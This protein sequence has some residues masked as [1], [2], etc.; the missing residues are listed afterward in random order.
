M[1][2]HR[3]GTSIA[4]K[5]LILLTVAVGLVIAAQAWLNIRSARKS[6]ETEAEQT[7]LNLYG[8]YTN[9]VRALEDSAAA[10][11]TSLAARSDIQDLF[12][13]R[14]RAGLVILLA[15]LF[16]TLA[17]NHDLV[18]LSI[19]GPTGIV[20]ARI[21]RPTQY[22]DNVSYRRAVAVALRTR[23]TVSGIEVGAN[24]L[25]IYSPSPLLYNGESDAAARGNFMG[26][27]EVALDY[28]QSFIEGLKM[29]NGA[30]YRMW[31]AREAVEATPLGPTLEALPAPT[32]LLFYYAG[33]T[34]AAQ[35]VPA[36]VFETVLQSGE[37][38]IEFVSDAGGEYAVLVA[39][40][41]AYGER[42]IGALEII[43]PH[44]DVRTNWQRG[45]IWAALI[46]GG[47]GLLAVGAT[48]FLVDQTG[49]RQ[50]QHLTDVIQRQLEGDRS[51]QAAIK[52]NDEIGRLGHAFNALAR[53]LDETLQG[54]EET[55]GQQTAELRRRS[56]LLEA[57]SEVGRIAAAVSDE[58]ELAAQTTTLVL[59]RF[60][61]YH[62]SI[63]F[64]DSKREWAEYI[65][66]AGAGA[67][68]LDKEKLRLEVGARSMVGWCIEHGQSRI[69]Q[70]AVGDKVRLDH[71]LM[72][73]TRSEAAFPLVARG[74]VIGALDVQSSQAGAFDPDM[75]AALEI[76]ADQ[77]AAALYAS[78]LLE[79]SKE[80]AIAAQR[81]YGEMSRQAWL[82]L[83]HERSEWGYR[84]ADQEVSSVEGG[85][86]P[87]ML[88]AAWTAQMVVEESEEGALLAVPVQVR[89]QVVGV[90]R[91]RKRANETSWSA[92]ERT[93]IENLVT[94]LEQ[95][96]ESGRLFLETQRR[97][98]REQLTRQ[99]TSRMRE[100]LDI[101]TV[102]Q[103][104]AREIRETMAL[105]HVAIRMVAP[106]EAGGPG[107]DDSLESMEAKEKE[108]DDE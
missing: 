92:E 29:H 73:E 32:P 40:I 95:A 50:L 102:L 42:T 75:V 79:E 106:G 76:I 55:V 14:D 99:A 19:E 26:L 16:E 108:T 57:A 74:Q 5:L 90:L 86:R 48:V 52:T 83:L 71:S 1:N 9:Q 31:I 11:S 7:L 4:L 8:D 24:H 30:D 34:T 78:R 23:S 17:A 49:L 96:L 63:F 54:L 47:L 13:A 37:P 44:A 21:H 25:G 107:T 77:V 88:Q 91:F 98:A 103:A 67:A 93:L 59:S 89:G 66:G 10:L 2:R 60:N 97:A 35:G 6:S 58:L 84:Y 69:A 12:L 43:V 65:A 82:D 100:T 15:P 85:W 20:F 56:S 53:Q 18:H 27:I 101:E 72:P 3:R 61:L 38:A 104:S 80:A 28:D 33:T 62:A 36:E 70:D 64:T 94:Q 39:P 51:A 41:E 105:E 87:E 22:G 45:P 81:V 68:T 46:A